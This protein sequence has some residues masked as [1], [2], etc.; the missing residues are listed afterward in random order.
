AY[1]GAGGVSVQL[2]AGS[3]VRAAIEQLSQQPGKEYLKELGNRSDIDWQRV[4]VLNKSLD[5]SKSG[6][7]KEATLAVIIA[8]SILTYGYASGWGASAAAG[9]EMTATAGAAGAVTTTTAAGATVTLSATGAAVAS[10]VSAGIT[11]LA[12]TAAVSLINNQGDIG[13]TLKELGSKENAQGLLLTMATAGLSNAVLTQAGLANVNA[14]SKIE[15]LFAKQA[16]QGLTSAV[17]ESAV[18]GTNLEDAIKNNLKSALINTVAAKGAFTIGEGGKTGD[19]N[20]A[21]KVIAHAL[22]GCAIGAPNAGNGSGCAPGAAGGAIGEIVAGLYA[23]ASGYDD[24]KSRAN[25]PG[26][27]PALKQQLAVVTNTMTEL[28]KLSGAGAALLIGG[29]ASSAQ[30]AM[31]TAA[32]VAINNRQLHIDER[33]LAQRLAVRSGGRY[34][35][36]Q[37]ENALRNS[38]NSA[39]GETVAT[40]M[41]VNTSKPD[42]VYDTGAT[43]NAG[44]PGTYTAVQTLPNGGQVDAA[45]ASFIQA[46]TGGANSPY[47]WS[48]G[49]LGQSSTGSSAQTNSGTGAHYETR[50]VDGRAYSVPVVD[51]PAASCANTDNVAR[52]GL[53]SQDQAAVA[54]YD[55]AVERQTAKG[56]G[57]ILIGGVAVAATPVTLVGAIGSGAVVG[58]TESVKNQVIDT[59]SI[60]ATQT[61]YDT[62]VGALVGVAVAGGAYV[63]GRLIGWVNGKPLVGFAGG[64]TALVHDANS[65]KFGS[66]D[67]GIYTDTKPMGTQF[68]NLIG[69]NPHYIENAGPGINTNCVSCVNASQARLTGTNP[70][71]VASPSSGYANANALLPS[72]PFGV[73]PETSVASV[74]QQMTAEGNGAVGVVLIKQPGGPSHVINVVNKGGQVYFVDTQMGKIVTLRPNLVVQL[75]LP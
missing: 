40:G 26:A 43:F 33:A 74:V 30:I 17:L 72:A 2:P 25:A 16:L 71:A 67:N 32:N 7:T 53:N 22:L 23:D 61:G 3:N 75:G 6:L 42:G 57:S 66:A 10:A 28:A 68:P 15:Q 59:G 35:V 37:I 70:T 52:Y 56:V 46:N 47:A 51:C 27:D 60:S 31:G 8:V 21:S 44:S 48:S 1:Q 38:G 11:S 64:Q 14:Q 13:A 41:V 50:V 24:L 62:A 65:V 54:A 12:S 4:E 58:G 39:L 5:F 45:L 20:A 63:A 29:D 55:A 69:V 34:T 18:L 73:Q 9:A 36:T 49:Q 19:L